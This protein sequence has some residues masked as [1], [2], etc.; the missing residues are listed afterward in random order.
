MKYKTMYS[1]YIN[2]YK[3]YKY[4]SDKRK[5]ACYTLK[6]FLIRFKRKFCTSIK[7]NITYILLFINLIVILTGSITT[8]L[9]F[10]KMDLLNGKVLVDKTPY[11]KTER[12]IVEEVETN[13]TE[14]EYQITFL[15]TAGDSYFTTRLSDKDLD[16]LFKQ[17]RRTKK[18][19]S[20][21]RK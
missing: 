21:M 7:K 20:K 9:L 11:T 5:K 12:V 14:M 19:V 18:N 1:I 6:L 16:Y 4:L 17:I 8:F 10:E 2:I 15:S 3:L 13:F